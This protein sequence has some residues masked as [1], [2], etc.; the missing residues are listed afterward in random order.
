MLLIASTNPALLSATGSKRASALFTSVY[1]LPG[2]KQADLPAFPVWSRYP[3]AGDIAGNGKK[4]LLLDDADGNNIAFG[5]DGIEARTIAA[6]S[7]RGRLVAVADVLGEGRVCLVTLENS[8]RTVMAYDRLNNPHFLGLLPSEYEGPVT[9]SDIDRDKRQDLLF[10]GRGYL[11]PK[12]GWVKF[13]YTPVKG[14]AA[15]PAVAADVMKLRRRQIAVVGAEK[16]KAG[17]VSDEL[18]LF[19]K[20]GKLVHHERFGKPVIGLAR[21]RKPDQDYLVVQF[22]DRLLIYP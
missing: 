20:D 21:I 19:D 6:Q 1:N 9:P 3:L 8:G 13:K 14:A 15:I 16:T 22:A 17:V 7:S 4:L 11:N 2:K 18:L 12:T 5:E 10:G